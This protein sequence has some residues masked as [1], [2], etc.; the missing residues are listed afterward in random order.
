M[1][2]FLPW[3]SSGFP[4]TRLTGQAPLWFLC[5]SNDHVLEVSPPCTVAFFFLSSFSSRRLPWGQRSFCRGIC[6]L[7]QSQ[8]RKSRSRFWFIFPDKDKTSLSVKCGFEKGKLPQA[9]KSSPQNSLITGWWIQNHG[10]GGSRWDGY[11]NSVLWGDL[12]LK[13]SETHPLRS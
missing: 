2:I 7:L 5:S 3:F 8:E 9:S 10:Q 12:L 11:A 4:D 6:L 1:W 13:A